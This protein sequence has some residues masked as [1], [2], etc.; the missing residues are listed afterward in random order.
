MSDFQLDLLPGHRII[1]Y[2]AYGRD[3]GEGT[4]ITTFVSDV[5]AYPVADHMFDKTD[6][7]RGGVRLEFNRFHATLEQGGT[8]LRDDQQAYD[9]TVNYGNSYAA[10]LWPD[11]RLDQSGAGLRHP[12]QQHL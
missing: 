5:N 2:L 12:R 3:S 7:Y 9:S 10:L 4:G 11:A 6:N 1:P 8:T